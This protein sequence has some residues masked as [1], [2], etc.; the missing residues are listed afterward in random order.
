[1]GQ[2]VSDI[3]REAALWLA[4]RGLP[5]FPVIPKSKAPATNNGFYS[6]TTDPD[7]VRKWWATKD[8]GIG[9]SVT[10]ELIVVDF[11]SN[12]HEHIKDNPDMPLPETW[13]TVTPGKGGGR[14]YWY[15]LPKGV[16]VGPKVRVMPGIDI[17]ASGSYVLV[18]PSEHPDGGK[19]SWE[20]EGV[21]ED[22]DPEHFPICPNWVIES[23]NHQNESIENKEK[24][25]L[26]KMLAGI[27]PGSRQV[28]LFRAACSMRARGFEKEEAAIILDGI[29]KASEGSGYKEYP[30]INKIIDRVWKRY[31]EQRKTD[32]GKM[33]TLDELVSADLGSVNWFVEDLLAPGLAIM[34]ADEKVGKSGLMA[35]TALSLATR[36]KVWGYY[37]VPKAR[38]VLYLDLEQDTLMGQSRWKKILDGRTPPQNLRVQFTWPRMD[39]GGLDRIKES[40]QANPDIEVVVIDIW[41]MFIPLTN[42]PG[43]NAY[44][45]EGDILDKLKKV[46]KEYGCLIVIVHHTNKD[47]DASGSRSM[48]GTPDYIFKVQRESGSRVGMVSVK[49]KNIPA[50]KVMFDVDPY[51]FKWNVTSVE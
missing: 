40:L 8:Y 49:G 34:Y 11:D 46:C 32:G 15:R 51:K 41:G 13:V 30:K 47:G 42:Q 9:V 50:V 29:A 38:G 36:E 1:V 28:G 14:H 20:D 24:V 27:E 31:D 2:E 16:I 17:R 22:L 12:A 23:C 37:L 18:P 5:V 43:S 26:I 21:L 3:L 33:W 25:S 35:N 7:V 4:S 19:Y 6:A 10:P 39:Q 48:L 44:Y 45:S